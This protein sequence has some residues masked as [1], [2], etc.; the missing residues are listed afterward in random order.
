ML[1]VD[2]LETIKIYNEEIKIIY[3]PNPQIWFI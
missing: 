3:N 2:N 1:I